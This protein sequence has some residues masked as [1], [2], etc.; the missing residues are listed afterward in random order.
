MTINTYQVH[1]V[2]R[3][4]GR[5]LSTGKRLARQTA[6]ETPAPADKITISTEARKKSVVDKVTS[7]IIDRI[8]H[9][10]PNETLE[11]EVF[12]ELEDEFGNPLSIGRK[13]TEM[14]FRAIGKRLGEDIQEL[15]QEDSDRL[16]ARLEEITRDKVQQ[17]MLQ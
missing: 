10:G 17:N 6:K 8:Y 5:Q 16:K 14:V 3:A 2:L 13:G 1:N 4:Y 7:D 12:K 11:K 15:S 9:E